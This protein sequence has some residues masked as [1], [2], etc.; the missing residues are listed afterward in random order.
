[1]LALRR[2]PD[3]ARPARSLRPRLRGLAVQTSSAAAAALASGLA[4]LRTS[5]LV[6]SRLASV[7]SR[8]LQ[9]EGAE[10]RSHA[11]ATLLPQPRMPPRPGLH[12]SVR[13]PQ[14]LIAARACIVRDGYD[15]VTVRGIADAA[16]ISTGTVLHYFA[17]KD[18][19]LE[20]ALL[21]KVQ[22]TGLALRAAL[23]GAASAW[24]RLERLV[25]ASLPAT[26]EVRDEW[27]LWLTFWGEATRNQ[28]LQAVSQRQHRRWTRFL[29]RIIVAGVAS[30]EFAA[31]PPNV[32]AVHIAALVDGL[33]VQATLGNPSLDAATMRQICL[34]GLARLL[35]PRPA[36]SECSA[37]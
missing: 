20:A 5:A 22:D 18:S 10:P 29:E 21:D 17:D 28:R 36:R 30:G 25:D 12:E 7:R 32:V 31:V 1:V 33:A 27:R 35:G 13:R 15:R 2:D 24:E 3:G 9:A 16:G 8:G 34:D 23:A 19:V 4:P 26:Q 14:I 11:G 6:R 37:D